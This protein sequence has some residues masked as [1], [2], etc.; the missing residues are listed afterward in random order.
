[1][2]AHWRRTNAKP[3]AKGNDEW[4]TPLV[5][6]AAVRKVLGGIDLDPA[7]H[8]H[9]QTWIQAKRFYTEVDDGLSQHWRGRVWLIPPYSRGLIDRFVAKLIA[10][11]EAGSVTAAILLTHTSS[12]ARWFHTALNSCDAI[13]MPLGKRPFENEDGPARTS[14]PRASTFFYFGPDPARFRR[15]FGPIGAVRIQDQPGPM[16][17]FT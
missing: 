4:F 13:C 16:A 7:A 3:N 6:I 9:P 5:Y 10:E 17:I 8:P 12:S 15:V 14:P 11:V 1:V 2:A